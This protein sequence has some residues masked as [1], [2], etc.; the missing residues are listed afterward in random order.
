MLVGL[1]RLTTSLRILG[2]VVA[3]SMSRY[4]GCE[5]HKKNHYITFSAELNL[6]YSQSF[7]LIETLWN[8]KCTQNR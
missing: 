7:S 4:N 3:A 2:W 6:K 1:S 8:A 5:K